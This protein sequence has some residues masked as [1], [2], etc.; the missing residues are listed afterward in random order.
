MTAG[1]GTEQRWLVPL[2]LGAEPPYRVFVNGIP[3]HEGDDYELHGHALAFD[4]PLEK[5][6][7]LGFWPWLLMFLS[8]RGTYRKNDSVD[9]Q[10]RHAGKELLAVGLDIVPPEGDSGSGS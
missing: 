6:G 2:P 1:P 10:Y 7:R 4:R 8:I 9:V 5:E 3:Q